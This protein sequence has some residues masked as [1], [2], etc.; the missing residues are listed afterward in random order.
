M[1]IF[2]KDTFVANPSRQRRYALARYPGLVG[3]RRHQARAVRSF[4][5]Y[6]AAGRVFAAHRASFATSWLTPLRR[7]HGIRHSDRHLTPL[8]LVQDSG[9]QGAGGAHFAKAER[10]LEQCS[11]GL[12][13]WRSRFGSDD[14]SGGRD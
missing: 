10:R 1:G 12:A 14:P 4:R 2:A 7:D 5:L 13:A 6:G 3:P 9:H 11:W 8:S